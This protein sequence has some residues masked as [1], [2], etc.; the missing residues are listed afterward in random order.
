MEPAKKKNKELDLV[1]KKKNARMVTYL[2]DRTSPLEES[3]PLPCLSSSQ[4][5]THIYGTYQKKNK[6]IDLDLINKKNMRP[7]LLD[8]VARSIERGRQ[9]RRLP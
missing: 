1:R 9:W 6:E 5:L 4:D 2:L 8:P 7:Y 3:P